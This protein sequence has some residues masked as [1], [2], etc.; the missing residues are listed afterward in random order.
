MTT[1]V[2]VLL[3][4]AFWG[5]VLVAAAEAS[6]RSGDIAWAAGAPL[7]RLEMRPPALRLLIS[8]HLNLPIPWA[9][10]NLLVR[11]DDPR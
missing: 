10:G 5:G 4:T 11:L 9:T 1:Q 3:S 8:R 2:R 6:K 7:A